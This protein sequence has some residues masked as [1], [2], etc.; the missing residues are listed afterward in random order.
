MSRI[1]R[2]PMFRG[3][4]VSS[5]GNG[6]A[7]GLAKGGSVQQRPGYVTGGA[8]MAGL[9]MLGRGGLKYGKKAL[10]YLIKPK[11]GYGMTVTGGAGGTGSKY[12]SQTMAPMSAKEMASGF[13]T[14]RLGQYLGQSPTLQLLGYGAKK[15]P[16]VAKALTS[17]EGLAALYFGGPYLKSKT[18][19]KIFP[20]DFDSETIVKDSGAIPGAIAE[21][22]D[23]EEI[24]RLNALLE[25]MQNKETAGSKST[26]SEKEE[27]AKNK[28]MYQE[29]MDTKGARIEDASNMALNFAG[30]ALS[31]GATVK[32]AM[33]EFFEE[34][35]KRPSKAGKIKDAA[36]AAA[37]N[38]YIAGKKSKAELDMYFAKLE[39]QTRLGKRRGDI[40]F[41][42]Q[43][44]GKV[45][46]GYKQMDLAVRNAFDGKIPTKVKTGEEFEITNEMIGEVFIEDKAPYKVFT[47]LEDKTKEYLY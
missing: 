41:H 2:R 18:Y 36:A 43:E 14:T 29:L 40:P 8:I 46:K 25:E 31:E 19:D 10:D 22:E 5:Y 39:G 38:Q 47:I 24:I 21:Q 35:G 4:K 7:T 27:L 20:G 9:G 37:I 28:K 12:L 34:E 30:K 16:G 26:L 23:N 32:S 3:G 33:S 1:L 15:V 17:P 45:A 42:L 11:G 13:G 44:A 6:I